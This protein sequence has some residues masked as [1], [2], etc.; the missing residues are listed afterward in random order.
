MNKKGF[1]KG[2]T[3][4]SDY[5]KKTLLNVNGDYGSSKQ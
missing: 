3:F 5:R 1:R 4:N 2:V